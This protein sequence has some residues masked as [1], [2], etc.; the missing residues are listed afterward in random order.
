MFHEKQRACYFVAELMAKVAASDTA[1]SDQ[2]TEIQQLK[3]Q[4]SGV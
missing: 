3:S 4:I 2:Q 1:S